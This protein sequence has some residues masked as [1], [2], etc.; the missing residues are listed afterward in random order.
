MVSELFSGQ[1]LAAALVAGSIYAL[2]ATGLNLIYGTMRLI[3]VAHGDL[4]MIGAYVAYWS[5]ALWGVGPLWSAFLA[6]ALGAAFG[7]LIYR[8]LF[9]IVMRSSRVAERVEA[10]S[11][12]VFFGILVSSRTV[13]WPWKDRPPR[14]ATTPRSRRPTS[15]SEVRRDRPFREVC[16]EAHR[17]R[18]QAPGSHA[19]KAGRVR[20]E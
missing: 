16:A 15:G 10:N 13:G 6:M 19:A 11:L 3:N 14:S 2:M 9:T 12:L 20:D 8:G 4:V 7:I 5:F 17:G 18:H 1:L